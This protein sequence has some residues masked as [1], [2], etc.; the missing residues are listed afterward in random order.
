MTS[1]QT[2]KDAFGSTFSK[3]QYN[4]AI[5]EIFLNSSSHLFGAFNQPAHVFLTESFQA[6]ALGLSWVAIGHMDT[7]LGE[8]KK[9]NISLSLKDIDETMLAGIKAL[10]ANIAD[11]KA[12]PT[13]ANTRDGVQPVKHS[14]RAA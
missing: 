10:K 8:L 11:D 2:L 5:H 6:R 1:Q 4:A 7:F 14:P 13:S 9:Q 3:A 12:K